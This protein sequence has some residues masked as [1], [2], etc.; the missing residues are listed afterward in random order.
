[1][2]NLI[3]MKKPWVRALLAEGYILALAGLMTWA[4]QF[5]RNRPDTFMAPVAVISIFTLSAA[6]MAYL[7]GLEPLM[8]YL[9]GKKKESIKWFLE[10]VGYFG[11][12][13]V[14]AVLVMVWL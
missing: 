4:T 11:A 2:Y 3:M 7:F 8:M 9:N 14:V 13:T 1:M 12:I 5:T 10:T 6:V